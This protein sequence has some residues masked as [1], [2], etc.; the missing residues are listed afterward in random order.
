VN[1][2]ADVKDALTEILNIGV[3]HAASTLNSLTGHRIQLAVPEVEINCLDKISASSQI[4]EDENVS[5]VSMEYHGGFEGS[6]SL[7]FPMQSADTLVTL[8]TGEPAGSAGMDELR[9]GTLA[10]VGNILLNGVM[11][12]LSNMLSVSLGYSMPLYLETPVN[13]MFGHQKAETVLMARAHFNIDDLHVEGNILL[14]FE[15][16]SF[17][18]LIDAVNRELLA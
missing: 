13:R 6:V 14:F 4:E 10:E 11:G 16:A 12:S 15:I 17:R 1:L 5:S 9:S 8:L 2:S 3:G 18:N 7:V